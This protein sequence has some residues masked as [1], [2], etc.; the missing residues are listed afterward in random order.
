MG[1]A[2]MLIFFYAPRKSAVHAAK[3]AHDTKISAPAKFL[4]RQ[5]DAHFILRTRSGVIN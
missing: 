3:P 2:Y 1:I 5:K 4:C